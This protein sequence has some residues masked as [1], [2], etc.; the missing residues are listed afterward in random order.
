MPWQLDPRPGGPGAVLPAEL[1]TPVPARAAAW[2][3]PCPVDKK[4][5]QRQP[6]PV[7]ELID[8][9]LLTAPGAE[10]AVLGSSSRNPRR[11]AQSPG[12][13]LVCVAHRCARGSWG[14]PRPTSPPGHRRP[15][16][17]RHD[18]HLVP[19]ALFGHVPIPGPHGLPGFV[20]L[21]QVPPGD[22][23]PVAADHGLDHRAGIG[24]GATSPVRAGS[25]RVVSSRWARRASGSGKCLPRCQSAPGIII[26]DALGHV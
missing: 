17:C 20:H 19:R 7:D 16:R 9:S 23:A 22:P 26:S 12:R 24:E 18:Q 5:D 1:G 10:A 14:P 6:G 11:A 2:G 21:G 15:L 3:S 8:L 25:T 4:A 13:G